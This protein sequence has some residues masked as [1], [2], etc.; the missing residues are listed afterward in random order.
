MHYIINTGMTQYNKP[1]SRV[2]KGAEQGIGSDVIV[3]C[4]IPSHGWGLCLH[5]LVILVCKL[6][7]LIIEL[8]LSSP[9]Y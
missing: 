3:L 1:V 5:Q 2:V 8:L 6:N 7:H 9:F 4:F